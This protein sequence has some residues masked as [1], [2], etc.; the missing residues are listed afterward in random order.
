M[1]LIVCFGWST[2]YFPCHD[3]LKQKKTKKTKFRS[4]LNYSQINIL[5]LKLIGFSSHHSQDFYGEWW[6]LP[7]AHSITHLSLR[8]LADCSAFSLSL[9]HLGFVASKG[10]VRFPLL[11]WRGAWRLG[12]LSVVVS[13]DR[14]GIRPVWGLHL[15]L[16][17][18]TWLLRKEHDVNPVG[19]HRRA[20]T[21]A[22]WTGKGHGGMCLFLKNK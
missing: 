3:D 1:L 6:N 15:S 8:Q 20:F 9:S 21:N 19:G 17:S 13:E 11:E 16:K 18:L 4:D 22:K 14:W 10:S 7:G 12:G 5:K 2:S